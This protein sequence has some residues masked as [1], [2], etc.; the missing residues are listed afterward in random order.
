MSTVSGQL[1]GAQLGLAGLGYLESATGSSGL[2]ITGSAGITSAEAF[3]TTGLVVNDGQVVSGTAGIAS[4]EAFGADGT[5]IGGSEGL[6]GSSGIPSAE[7]FGT[8]GE[9]DLTIVGSAGIPSAEA[10]GTLGAVSQV[11]IVGTAG[12]PSAEAFGTTGA[13]Q[14]G[15][16]GTNGG[17]PSAE[18]FGSTG[19]VLGTRPFTLFIAGVDRT[20]Y[21][22]SDSMLVSQSLD[23]AGTTAQFTLEDP[24]GS[25][26][27][28]VGQEV[29]YYRGF[30][31]HFGGTIEET[32]VQNWIGKQQNQIAVKCNDW[33]TILARRI[34]GKT[35]DASW[36]GVMSIIVS[37]IAQSYL[38][39]DG[40]FYEFT[41]DPGINIG[42]QTFNWITAQEA[43]NQLSKVSGWDWRVDFYKRLFI[44]PSGVGYATAP[45]ALADNDGVWRNMLVTS[46]RS[47][48]RNRQGVRPSQQL[49]TLY[50]DIFGPGN[51]GPYPS[52]P[53]NPNGTIRFFVTAQK[54]NAAPLVTVND[55][56]QTVVA[57][58]TQNQNP[59]WQWYWIPDGYGVQQNPANAALGAGDTL[60]VSYPGTPPPIIWVQNN[61]QIAARAAIEDN[62]GIYESVFE[63]PD[64]TDLGAATALANQLLARYGN[65]GPT[66]Q[67]MFETDIDGLEIGQVI[68]INTTRPPVNNHFLI[69]KVQMTEVA[70]TYLRYQVTAVSG[71]VQDDWARF[72]A[73]LVRR[74]KL[75]FPRTTEVA[76]F[77]IAADGTLTPPLYVVRSLGIIRDVTM[78][79]TAMPAADVAFNLIKNP[80]FVGIGPGSNWIWKRSDVGA[81]LTQTFYNFSQPPNVSPGDNLSP[82]IG[83][84]GQKCIL[85]VTIDT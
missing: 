23:N 80:G 85:M 55:I 58:G 39:Q 67:V 57:L 21:L 79:F 35:Y 70:K 4:A 11:E 51:P 74:S 40:I 30:V 28:T 54:L 77:T 19:V 7:A 31:R 14:F 37:D 2:T 24:A 68:T 32:G 82:L 73:E 64:V 41:G 83:A 16:S 78:Q 26:F 46:T 65:A 9:V 1:G 44:F 72:Y 13:I 52:S 12:I 15:P 33:S 60:K 6:A 62:S 42:V 61:S 5:V 75:P 81:P 34:V 56:A 59:G 45:F 38:Q 36:G 66:V 50:S 71:A 53:Q 22:A 17:I 76:L 20:D 84:P 8:T 27:P 69:Q 25:F 63:A 49:V 29:L 3:G 43:L 18:K 47:L 10:F 48:Y